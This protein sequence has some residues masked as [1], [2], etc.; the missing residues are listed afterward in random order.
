MD[1]RSRIG[2]AKDLPPL[3]EPSEALPPN[4][5]AV[6]V[7]GG[8]NGLTCATYLAQS[9]KKV[10][11]IEATS[12]L[13]GAAQSGSIGSDV[14]SSRA[15]HIIRH[16]D[17]KT[18]SRLKLHRHGFHYA[19]KRLQTI[20]LGDDGRH[21][22]FGKAPWVTGGSLIDLSE[23]DAEK[24]IVFHRQISRIAKA[25]WQC[26]RSANQ[27]ASGP[28][29]QMFEPAK[30]NGLKDADQALYERMVTS[31]VGHVLEETFE[32]PL[33]QGALAFEAVLGRAV[34]PY[35]PGTAI[36]MVSTWAGEVA[37]HR[38]A[39]GL[40]QGGMGS[41]TDALARS[42]IHSGGT[43]RTGR[44]V[45]R[46]LAEDGRAEGVELEGGARIFAPTI[47]CAAANSQYLFEGLGGPNMTPWGNT[48]QVA[49]SRGAIA[50]LNLALDG[51]PSAKGFD[52]NDQ[53][54]T[55]FVIAPSLDAI[56]EAFVPSKYGQFSPEPIMEI[57][58]PSLRDSSLSDGNKHA[59]SI[60]VQF[61]PYD[62]QGG[63]ESSRDKFIENCAKVLSRYFPDFSARIQ[64]GE[65]LAPPDLEREF[66]VAGG[67]WHISAQGPTGI[68]STDARK[69]PVDGLFLCGASN[70]P[71]GGVRG[72]SGRLAAELILLGP[73]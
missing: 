65:L 13:G 29:D 62:L 37:G 53:P 58:F 42:L 14:R 34:S 64:G 3:V 39:M 11:L 70:H 33:L 56:E 73:K 36:K 45:A 12:S 32:T 52:I 28:K 55:R 59:A 30:L 50:K 68:H 20:A 72:T 8:I 21:I 7:G 6:V 1:W 69:G 19:A 27:E 61:A 24:Y 22:H 57:V 4:F 25:I 17:P 15:A 48:R 43:Y 9:G 71:G 40:P 54:D 5:D 51:L 31:S 60:V 18:T 41:L 2:L 10:I 49:P 63:W 44:R 35:W 67:N 66:G 46:V 26:D 16:F 38:G 47:V 23:K